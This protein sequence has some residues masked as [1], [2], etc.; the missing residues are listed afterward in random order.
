M[1]TLSQDEVT[2]TVWC[3]ILHIQLNREE[4]NKAI[5]TPARRLQTRMLMEPKQAVWQTNK[6]WQAPVLSVVSWDA[7]SQCLIKNHWFASGSWYYQFISVSKT[8]RNQLT[9]MYAC[10]TKKQPYI[11]SFKQIM[12][13]Q[14]LATLC[15]A[16]PHLRN[17]QHSKFIIFLDVYFG[18]LKSTHKWSLCKI[19]SIKV[20]WIMHKEGQFCCCH[21]RKERE[22][23]KVIILTSKV[24][25]ANFSTLKYFKEEK[26]M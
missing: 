19:C 26:I 25:N 18:E 6:A 2:P 5:F 20:C 3:L 24:L 4:L 14:Y 7:L 9:V 16:L 10:S 1:H 13:K 23:W 8:T 22:K 12:A 21:W 11:I 17:I 15:L